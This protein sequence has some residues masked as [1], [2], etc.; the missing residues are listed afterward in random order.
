MASRVGSRPMGSDG[1]D[2]LHRERIAGHYQS[3]ATNK[4][5][6][7]WTIYLHF[8]L[9]LLMIFRLSVSF[10]VLLNIRPPSFLQRMR[11]PRAWMW[12]YVWLVSLMASMFGLFSLRKNRFVLMQQFVIG[13]II[14]GLGPVAYAMV[15][16]F[17]E[18]VK[19]WETRETTKLF[20]GFP[21]VVLWNMFLVIALQLHLFGLWFAWN[22]LRAWKPRGEK[23][24]N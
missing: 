23:K 8:L 22:L 3:S 2:F 15:T 18:L 13:W 10:F 11:L 16:L 21:I 24:K 9:G 19:Y 4:S 6:F 17:D 12:E 20:L 7:K 5:R 1:T 14:F